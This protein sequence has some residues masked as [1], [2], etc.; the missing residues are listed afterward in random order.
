MLGRLLTTLDNTLTSYPM[1]TGICLA[2][3]T[4]TVIYIKVI[5]LGYSSLRLFTLSL[6]VVIFQDLSTT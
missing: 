2:N 3:G 4:H 5:I 6:E 1:L